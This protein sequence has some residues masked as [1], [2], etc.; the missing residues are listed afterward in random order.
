MRTLLAALLFVFLTPVQAALPATF[1]GIDDWQTG[2]GCEALEGDLTYSVRA[3]VVVGV[4]ATP[5][6]TGRAV[7][8]AA[9]DSD[10]KAYICLGFP[11]NLL[12]PDFTHRTGSTFYS[13]RG[14]T[15]I[16]DGQQHVLCGVADVGSINLYVDGVLAGTRSLSGASP[17]SR[18]VCRYGALERAGGARSTFWM[19]Q[20]RSV[21]TWDR[22]LSPGEIEANCTDAPPPPT[23]EP[24]HG[25]TGLVWD[26]YSDTSVGYFEVERTVTGLDSW[27]VAGDTLYKNRAEWTDEE[28][29]VYPAIRGETWEVLR[30]W[31]LPVEN[32]HY[33]YRVKAV[34]T[35]DGQRSAVSNVVDCGP[36]NPTRCYQSGQLVPCADLAP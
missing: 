17:S 3:V 31:S 27:S 22:A 28:G 26:A 14:T 24:C 20:I 5:S 21:A 32:V 35:S 6:S 11:D 30:A 1:D 33:S 19:G 7:F 2:V 29:T 8:C 36:Q 9:S 12:I 16:S 18:P 13:A 10:S 23:L 4:G 15:T 25:H 34:R